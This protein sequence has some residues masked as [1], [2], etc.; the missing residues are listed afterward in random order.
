MATEALGL[1]FDIG[2]SSAWLIWI[3]PFAAAMII[4]GVGRL[5]K[6]ATGY[7]AVAFALMSAH[8]LELVIQ[9]R[10]LR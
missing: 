7:L 10:H 8:L 6:H 9:L 5:S 2:A 3:S 1:P 4:P